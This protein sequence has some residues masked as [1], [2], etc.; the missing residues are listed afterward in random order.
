MDADPARADESLR[1]VE[2]AGREALAEMRRLLGV[3]DGGMDPAPLAPPPGLA[4]VPD[5]VSRACDS[6]IPA[7]LEVHGDPAPL[8]PA[9]ELCTYRIVQEALTN[10]I[11][12]AGPASVSV[13]MTWSA[14][15]LDVVVTDDG[16][17]PQAGPADAG[18][19]GLVGMRERAALHGGRIDAGAGPAGGFVVRAHLPLETARVA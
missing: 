15:A 7:S 14:G 2:R 5:L 16:P 12:H 11:K 1:V 10:A 8:T 3:M 9:L 4:D 17:G 6:G 19:H 13:V 18:G